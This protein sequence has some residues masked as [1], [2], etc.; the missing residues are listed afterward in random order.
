MRYCKKCVQPDTRPGIYFNE[1]GICGACLYQE[2]AKKEIDWEARQEELQEIAHWAKGKRRAYDCVIGVSGGKDSTFQS[3]YARDVLGLRPLLV[4]SEP[5]NITEVG[6]HNIENLKN[7]GFDVCALRPNP[8]VMKRLIK[9][10]FYRYLNPVKVTEYSLWHSAYIVAQ[11]FKIPLIIQGENPG[12]TLGVRKKTGTGGDALNFDQQDTLEK[13][14][15]SEYV[16]D[17]IEP[18]DLFLFHSDRAALQQEGIRAIWLGY[19]VKEWSQPGNAAFS[20]AHGL[21]IKP[22]DLDLHDIGTYRRFSQ[23]DS[24]LVQVN[25]MLKHIKFGFGQA[26]DHACYD[27]REGRISREEGIA[28]VKGF[29]GKCAERYIQQF[30]DYIEIPLEEFWNVAKGF[31]G[32][33][34]QKEAA[35]SWDLTNP[36]WEQ[37]PVADVDVEKV[38]A[39]LERSL[40][41]EIE[42]QKKQI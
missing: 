13:D 21:Q 38:I 28:L 2:Q 33:M 40:A 37:E 1:K 39:S 25:Q 30:C 3:L 35:G 29:D 8:Q 12:L 4:N 16:G 10:D 7:L 9:K 27:I 34:W 22:A 26:T 41:E 24:D 14:Y 6:R 32:P 17:G 11:A 36:I 31:Y 19:Y 18:E 15:L 5:E 42:R 20:I 23:L